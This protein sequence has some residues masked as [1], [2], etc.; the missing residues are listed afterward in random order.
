MYVFLIIF[1]CILGIILEKKFNKRFGLLALFCMIWIF[2]VFLSSLELYEMYEV[3]N[4]IYFELLLGIFSFIVGYILIGYGY[5]KKREYEI[6]EK[7]YK[8]EFNIKII[9]ILELIGLVCGTVLIFKFIKYMNLGY[10]LEQIRN[11]YYNRMKINMFESALTEFMIKKICGAICLALIPIVLIMLFENNKKYR[12]SIFGGLLVILLNQF[13]IGGRIQLLIIAVSVILCLSIYKSKIS[14]K[15]IK[16]ILKIAFAAVL[17]ILF[18]TILRKRI[19]ENG[20]WH[21]LFENIYKY[22]TLA[23]PL[24]DHWLKWLDTNNTL[25]YGVGFISGILEL[26]APIAYKLFGSYPPADIIAN[27]F[28]PIETNYIEV[29]KNAYCNAYVTWIFALYADF[30][31]FGVVIGSIFFGAICG[32]LSNKVHNNASIYSLTLYILLAQSIIKSFVRWE[33][34]VFAYILSFIILKICISKKNTNNT[35]TN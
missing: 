17:M 24:S 30:R 20:K 19:L 2:I 12:I 18:I 7:K 35:I 1:V 3:S 21:L 5:I 29:Y 25:T 27:V 13:A 22:F 8:Y 6:E 11:I 28:H 16:R 10:S 4:K 23:I 26:F 9:Y 32:K 15:L 14:K 34:S 31:E 33:F